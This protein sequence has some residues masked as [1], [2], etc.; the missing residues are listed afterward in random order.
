MS[1]Y[2]W[3]LWKNEFILAA[4]DSNLPF[5]SQMSVVETAS[6]LNDVDI[7]ISQLRIL[8]RIVRHKIGDKLFKLETKMI[9]LFGEM[10]APQFGKYKCIPEVWSESELILY[11]VRDYVA[12]FKKVTTLLTNSNQLIVNKIFRID[13]IVGGDH[14]QGTFKFPMKLLFAMKSEKSLNVKVVLLKYY[15]NKE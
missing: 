7:Y 1:L 13:I 2:Y 6:M 8:F 9:D 12:I 5:T 4:G 3:L 14:D 15:A 10:I 11:R